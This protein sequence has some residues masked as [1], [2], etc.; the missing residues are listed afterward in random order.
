V[1][2]EKPLARLRARGLPEPERRLNTSAKRWTEDV[3][4]LWG[5]VQEFPTLHEP[6]GRGVMPDLSVKGNRFFC[7]A[8]LWMQRRH[9][10]RAFVPQ[11]AYIPPIPP[12][13]HTAQTALPTHSTVQATVQTTVYTHDVDVAA[14]RAA[15]WINADH[16][17][18]AA[19]RRTILFQWLLTSPQP[20]NTP[21]DWDW[22]SYSFSTTLLWRWAERLAQAQ[23]AIVTAGLAQCAALRGVLLSLAEDAVR[24]GA[25]PTVEALWACNVETVRRLDTR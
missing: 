4:A 19:E 15:E 25:L 7:S 22:D 6:L 11:I 23:D 2:L 12:I 8:W 10:T 24:R 21:H 13:A 1:L 9:G 3:L 18:G 17:P 14:P 5:I 16:T 20:E